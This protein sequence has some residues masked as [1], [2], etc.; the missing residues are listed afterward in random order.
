MQRCQSDV[1]GMAVRRILYP[2][3]GQQMGRPSRSAPDRVPE[4]EGG[5][6][7]G[8]PSRSARGTRPRAQRNAFRTSPCPH[9]S[10]PT[11]EHVDGRTLLGIFLWKH[12]NFL[13]TFLWRT[14]LGKLLIIYRS[15]EPHIIRQTYEHV[16][17]QKLKMKNKKK[18]KIKIKK[19]KLKK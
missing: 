7:A 2:W 18:I 12:S 17:V 6:P 15:R 5:G 11:S 9:I 16:Y 13:T 1:N 10:R 14:L 8:R 19:L 3:K 4:E